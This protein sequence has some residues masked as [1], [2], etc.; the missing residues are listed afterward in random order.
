MVLKLKQVL[1]RPKRSSESSASC[2][3]QTTLP[4]GFIDA[5][6]FANL[7]T[8]AIRVRNIT[9]ALEPLLG[10]PRE[11]DLTPRTL[12]GRENIPKNVS[13]AS[14]DPWYLDRWLASTN[15]TPGMNANFD[16][17]L[18]EISPSHAALWDCYPSVGNSQE[19]LVSVGHPQVA[20][21]R[22]SFICDNVV[23]APPN[24]PSEAGRNGCPD[25]NVNEESS[26]QGVTTERAETDVMDGQLN[27]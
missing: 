4:T 13:A 1:G 18:P 9:A 11:Q 16:D 27:L 2:P 19:D 17:G 20:R 6:P 12:V 15:R 7:C 3:L 5:D 24:L 14:P 21:F 22:E 26:N 8:G 10:A 25:G 23:F